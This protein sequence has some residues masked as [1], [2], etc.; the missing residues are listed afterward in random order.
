M[1]LSIQTGFALE[2]R[3][4]ANGYQPPKSS[5]SVS[6]RSTREKQNPLLKVFV[7]CVFA[8]VK[9]SMQN[10][11]VARFLKPHSKDTDFRSRQS[12][13]PPPA[14]LD[15]TILSGRNIL[16]GGPGLLRGRRRLGGLLGLGS[17]SRCLATGGLG[18]R[19]CPESLF[20]VSNRPSVPG[21]IGSV[22]TRL[23]RSNCMMRVESL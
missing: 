6:A 21:R 4:P 9:K 20:I 18:I 13:R 10:S 3:G 12:P 11:Q 17:G 23:S 16:L 22:L 5:S 19:R 15:I 14:P 2:S 7:W 8:I 1:L